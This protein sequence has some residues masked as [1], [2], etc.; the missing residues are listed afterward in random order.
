MTKPA[1]VLKNVTK[2]FVE[3]AQELVVLREINLEIN[4]GE[5]FVI[6]GPSGSG[7]STLLRI[8]SGLER[9]FQ[10]KRELIEGLQ[11]SDFSFV[12]QQF[13]LLPWLTVLENVEVSL[14]SRNLP[15]G[16][17]HSKVMAELQKLGL[18][19][20]AK[21]FPKELSGGMKQRVGLARALVGQPQVIF[22][23]EPFSSLDSF[24][25]AELRQEILSIWQ[26]TG[27]TVVMVTHLIPEALEL[28]DRIAVL[29][30]RPGQI[31]AVVENG[32]A[33]PRQKRSLEFFGF[34]DRL[35]DLVKF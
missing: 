28:A 23:D 12:F 21:S 33:R 14:L 6:L 5:F 2:K 34:E 19:K 11:Q 20:F 16:E 27:S 22:M 17:R 1:L 30:A 13:A 8:L 24:T 3:D 25:A 4:Q 7:K 18:E 29:T 15:A 35:M 32:L 9:N 10:G 31:E 26:R